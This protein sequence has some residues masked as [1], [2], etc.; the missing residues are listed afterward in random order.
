MAERTQQVDG[1]HRTREK[2]D[3][4]MENEESFV[5]S[6]WKK[7]HV[8]FLSLEAGCGSVHIHARGNGRVWGKTA[9]VRKKKLTW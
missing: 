5:C 1:A 2:D 4:Q 3:K 9:L 6:D 8:L 7:P